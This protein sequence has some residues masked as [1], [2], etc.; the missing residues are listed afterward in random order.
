MSGNQGKLNL[1]M[2]LLAAIGLLTACSKTIVIDSSCIAYHPIIVSEE[3]KTELKKSK[4]SRPFIWG[5]A[6]FNGTYRAICEVK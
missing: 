5:I 3:D 1:K 2:L 6:D 4:L